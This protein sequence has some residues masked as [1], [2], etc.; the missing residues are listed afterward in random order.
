MKKGH[1]LMI[2][3]VM[4]AVLLT[5]GLVFAANE[6]VKGNENGVEE[7]DTEVDEP[8]RNIT[9][10]QCVVEG[11]QIRNECYNSTKQV[12]AGCGLDAKSDRTAAGQCSSNYKIAMKQCKSEFKTAKRECIQTT[13]PGLWER[14]RYSFA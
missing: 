7:N 4:A 5:A 10:G 9:Y 14:I 3:A 13:K 6:D 12:R 11:V 1:I 8:E 2:F